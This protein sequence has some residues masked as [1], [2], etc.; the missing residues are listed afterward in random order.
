MTCGSFA[1]LCDS[2]MQGGTANKENGGMRSFG[3]V[4]GLLF[5]SCLPATAAELLLPPGASVTI[6]DAADPAMRI[7]LTSP[8]DAPLD[9]TPLLSLKVG[10]S[11]G[12]IVTHIQAKAAGGLTMNPDGSIA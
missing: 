12:S 10:E 9:L 8:A 6:L 5:F 1:D 7:V 4:L 3:A 2:S 11:V